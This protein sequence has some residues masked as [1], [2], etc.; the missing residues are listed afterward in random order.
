MRRLL[1]AQTGLVAVLPRLRRGFDTF[2]I[3]LA[4]FHLAGCGVK[5]ESPDEIFARAL[6]HLERGDAQAKSEARLA[7]A[8]LANFSD[9]R[10]Q[11]AGAHRWMG[12][13]LFAK[14]DPRRPNAM[15]EDLRLAARHLNRAIELGAGDEETFLIL[16][17]IYLRTGRA[18]ESI[19]LLEDRIA[20]M[21][22]L[23]VHLAWS[24]DES[25]ESEKVASPAKV[26]ARHWRSIVEREPENVEARLR[27]AR[28]EMLGGEAD[29]ALRV[30]E[31]GKRLHPDRRYASFS[32]NVRLRQAEQAIASDPPRWEEAIGF[33]EEAQRLVPGVVVVIDRLLRIAEFGA[34]A[35]D[36]VREVFQGF[37][38]SG[39]AGWKVHS[40][41]GELER[42]A[43]N[44]DA[45]VGHFRTARS[46]S[47]KNPFAGNDLAWC[48]AHLE[49]PRLEE[50]LKV[51]DQILSLTP[52][53]AENP[54]GQR[55]RGTILIKLGRIEE[56]SAELEKALPLL[57]SKLQEELK[58]I[59]AAARASKDGSAAD[60]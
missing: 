56:G 11:H 18:K 30:L 27:W 41:L 7:L 43:G 53:F 1:H 33:L 31:E 42:D 51:S 44:L 54:M 50:A 21:P 37:V 57:D 23:A 39:L 58:S 52:A 47:P 16:A 35:R 20:T 2:A 32:A 36:R 9:E 17:Q 59:L 24:Y 26:G 4:A 40:A 13:E 25:G 8:N 15:N 19:A 34:G 60:K 28:G 3:V 6:E 29:E 22:G 5:E 48:L 12:R 49:P 38:D 55:T 10:P 46:L 14:A 45:A